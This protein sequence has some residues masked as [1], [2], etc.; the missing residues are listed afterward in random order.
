M[1]GVS[2]IPPLPLL[3][4]RLFVHRKIVG[5]ER[6]SCLCRWL[7]GS[8]LLAG[9]VGGGRASLEEH[10]CVMQLLAATANLLL[11]NLEGIAV[12]HVELQRVS[13]VLETPQEN[14][15]SPRWATAM[16]STYRVWVVLGG[17][18]LTVK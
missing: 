9:W 5:I 11:V 18:T 13:H 6:K 1:C 14:R 8:L 7:V 4:S 12:L 16:T 17:Y 3:I 10:G 2:F 15:K